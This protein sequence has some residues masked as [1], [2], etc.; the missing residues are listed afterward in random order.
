M[1]KPSGTTRE[2]GITSDVEGLAAGLI[3]NNLTFT[4]NTETAQARNSKGQI[5]DIA[6]FSKSE[7]VNVDGLYIGTGV[8][9]GTVVNIGEKGYLVTNSTKTEANT[10]F[11]QGSFTAMTADEAV[12]WPTSSFIDDTT[13]P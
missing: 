1:A 2:F 7:E 3:A 5:I 13:T 10:D 8:E 11:Q 6:A 4:K 12:L 9:P